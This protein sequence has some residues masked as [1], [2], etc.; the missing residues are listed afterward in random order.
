MPALAHEEA[1]KRSYVDGNPKVWEMVCRR[2]A[3]HVARRDESA[4]C[5]PRSASDVAPEAKPVHTIL[6]C[7]RTRAAEQPTWD[8]ACISRRRQPRASWRVSDNPRHK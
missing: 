5:H 2:Q 4:G 8:A 3:P 7:A 6:C 1:R